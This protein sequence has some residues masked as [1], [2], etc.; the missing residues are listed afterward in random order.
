MV[1]RRPADV[2]VVWL[3]MLGVTLGWAVAVIAS[4]VVLF[5]ILILFITLG[6]V[7]STLSAVL[8]FLLSSLFFEGVCRCYWRA[9]SGCPSSSW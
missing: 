3:I 5:P 4:F 8:V 6:S 1:R 2:L 7:A 9:C